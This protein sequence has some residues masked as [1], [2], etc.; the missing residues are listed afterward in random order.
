VAHLT[1]A[2]GWEFLNLAG[3]I[4]LRAEVHRY[5]LQRAADALAD[6]RNGRFSGVAVLVP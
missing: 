3:R 5:P 6:L 4:P 1:R 2:D